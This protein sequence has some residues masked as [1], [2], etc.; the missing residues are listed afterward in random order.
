[1]ISIVIL[2]LGGLTTVMITCNG[3]LAS[4]AG[5][6]PAMVIIHATGLIPTAAIWLLKPDKINKKKAPF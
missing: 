3:M 5:Q 1:M 6:I 2:L 4:L